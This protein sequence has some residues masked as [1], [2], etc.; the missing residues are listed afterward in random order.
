M[1]TVTEA[2]SRRVLFAEDDSDCR[3]L[4]QLAAQ[5]AGIEIDVAHNGEEALG[6]FH[7]AMRE[8][9]PYDGVVLDAV[10]PD[11]SGYGVASR[12]REHDHRT[13]IAFLTAYVND[14]WRGWA[15]DLEVAAIWEKPVPV[16]KLSHCLLDWLNDKTSP[17]DGCG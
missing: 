7:R 10:M 5:S 2:S 1:G 11:V 16:D 14:L 17:S 9:H 12:I 15:R 4:M 13:R 3:A 8:G 6:L